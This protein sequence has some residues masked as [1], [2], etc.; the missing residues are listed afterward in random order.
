MGVGEDLSQRSVCLFVLKVSV[1]D[2]CRCGSRSVSMCAFVLKVGCGV[3]VGVDLDQCSVCVFVLNVTV[4]D[5]CRCGFGQ[6]LRVS[7]R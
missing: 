2:G 6:C 7:V 1:V 4:V 3:G 5:G